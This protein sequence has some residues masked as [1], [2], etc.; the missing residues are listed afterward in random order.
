MFR[1][2]TSFYNKQ[3]HCFDC[4]KICA[5]A[6]QFHHYNKPYSFH[7]SCTY[8][9]TFLQQTHRIRRSIVIM[10]FD[11]Y[12]VRLITFRSPLNSRLPRLLWRGKYWVVS[13]STVQDIELHTQPAQTGFYSSYFSFY[14]V[15][16]KTTYFKPFKN[17]FKTILKS[18]LF[19]TYFKAIFIS[20]RRCIF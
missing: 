9:F 11:C 10:D 12:T 4:E 13:Q 15:F 8:L 14:L 17:D 1:S 18:L 3:V 19:E 6:Q 5:C 20:F 7:V 2:P 16:G